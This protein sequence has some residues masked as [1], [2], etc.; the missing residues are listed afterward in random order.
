MLGLPSVGATANFFQ[1]GGH[2][3]LATRMIN[4]LAEQGLRLALR[5]IFLHPTI[6]ALGK[7]L[8]AQ[9]DVATPPPLIG[10]T[11]AS[12]GDT[13]LR[14]LASHAQ[15]RLWFLEQLNPTPGAYHINCLLKVESAFDRQGFNEAM[16]RLVARHPALRTRFEFEN[17]ELYQVVR[18]HCVLDIPFFDLARLPAAEAGAELASLCDE[19]KY[20]QI[21]LGW[22]NPFNVRVI[23]T[24]PQCHYVFLTF[25]HIVCDGWSVDVFL[26]ELEQ[27]YAAHKARTRIELPALQ[28]TYQD[29]S[30]WQREWLQGAELDALL[31]YWT[32][33]LRDAPAEHGVPLDR[34]RPSRPSFRGG[35]HRERLD[36]QATARLKSLLAGRNA[37]LFVGLKALFCA[38]LGR[39]SGEQ[40]IVIGTAVANRQHKA[41]EGVFGYFANTVALRQ[42]MSER[43]SLHELVDDARD[44]FLSDHAHQHLPFEML[45]DAIRPERHAAM[46]PLFQIMFVLQNVD[47]TAGEGE[48]A[49][50]FE[51]QDQE[52]GNSQFDITLA[53]REEDDALVFAWRYATDLFDEGTIAGMASSFVR[54]VE[55][56]VDAPRSNVHALPILDDAEIVRGFEAFNDTDC[57]FAE[58]DALVHELIERWAARTPDGIAVVYGSQRLTYRELNAHANALAARLLDAGVGAQ[59]LVGV[60][61]GPSIEMVVALLAALKAGAAYLPLDPSY[62]EARI[63]HMLE[64]AGTTLVLVQDST[65]VLAEAL[66]AGADVSVLQVEAGLS[67]DLSLSDIP[68]SRNGAMQDGLAY[69]IY[70]S[71][72]TGLPKGVALH[73]RGLVNH[74]LSQGRLFGVTPVSRMM[75]YAALS[76][77][78]ATCEIFVALCN[79]AQLHVIDDAMKKQPEA[80]SRLIERERLTHMMLIPSVLALLAPERMASVESIIVGGETISTEQADFWSA[81]HRV[82]NAYGPSEATI[83]ALSEEYAGKGVA[84]GHPIDNMKAY[85]L[86]A[87]RMLVPRQVPGELYLAGVGLARGYLGQAGLEASR[88][89]EHRFENGI[90]MRLYRTGDLVRR[91]ADGRIEFL[92]RVDNQVK[93][94][95]YRI[96]TEEVATAI[97]RVPGVQTAVVHAQPLASGEKVLVAYIVAQSPVAEERWGDVVATIRQQLTRDLPAYML[98][99]DYLQL[100]A[101]PTLAN[102][103]VDRGALPRP[104]MSAASTRGAADKPVTDTEV[105]LCALLS[106]VIGCEDVGLSDNFFL[107]G[108][109]SI[110]AMKL[111]VRLNAAFGV[112][113]PLSALFDAEDVRA[114]SQQIDRMRHSEAFT[115]RPP[116]RPIEAAVLHGPLSYEQQRI[117][118]LSEVDGNKAAYNA[119]WSLTI[120]GE[121]DV[122]ALERALSGLIDRHAVLRT[123][124]RMHDGEPMQEVL[125]EPVFALDFNDVAALAPEAQDEAIAALARDSAARP[126]DLGRD[127]MLRACL[128][129]RAERAHVLV[130]T[131]HHIAC[132]GWS[133]AVLTRELN[134]LYRACAVGAAD[135]R[136]ALPVQYR[137]YAHWQR[138]WLQGEVL[139]AARGYWLSRLDGMPQVHQLPLDRP[140]PA[141][142]SYRGAMYRQ[143][144]PASLR[145]SLEALSQRSQT[146]LFMTVQAAFALLLGRFS[147]ERDIVMGTAIANREQPEVAELIGLFANTLVLRT[148]WSPEWSFAELLEASRRDL[149]AD[150]AHQHMPFELLVEAINP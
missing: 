42:T 92:G 86:D 39:Y 89:I 59:A 1:L 80:L 20:G 131:L 23:R 22:D 142:P 132:D 90:A 125:P 8:A 91:L 135:S 4:R 119:S 40:D 46:N 120:D 114:L 102:G 65:A 121:L 124:V 27:L 26:G 146:T 17:D 7:A 2:S 9:T 111:N 52:R 35:I 29:Y 37:S 15:A 13:D 134:A 122:R 34:P 105:A 28:A 147:G 60:F 36:A 72:S 126:F 99:A 14:S 51:P 98:P 85:I 128:V 130:L 133:M 109:N 129:R 141:Q 104:V 71:G 16:S 88:F 140:R 79:G 10:G 106:E 44:A 95:G 54:L 48:V 64:D 112:S 32:E 138:Q 45:V 94:R 78:V 84:I 18:P 96:E 63:R 62:P 53:V 55:A 21:D 70:T 61:M 148:Q 107:L 145:Q 77:D 118:F 24:T 144:L 143:Q 82:F 83:C 38:L 136:P 30:R 115:K 110:L 87:H 149:L 47:A 69:A 97:C 49:S 101:L 108:G 33:R 75:Q 100:P 5:Q 56:A 93:I 139:E 12:A 117:W 66:V 76:F 81:R 67:P 150:F 19:Q 127:L 43:Q 116:I 137:D 31:G 50:V 58:A 11:T 3:L 113:L 68:R 74:V 123:V 57:T 6:R 25:H 41:L 73:H 103:K